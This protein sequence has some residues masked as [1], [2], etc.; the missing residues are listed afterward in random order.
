MPSKTPG[1]M[2]SSRLF[3]R[4][5]SRWRAG[6]LAMSVL[7]V[8]CTRDGGGEQIDQVVGVIEILEANHRPL[9]R[10]G[11]VAAGYPVGERMEL[12]DQF[13]V[14][15]RVRGGTVRLVHTGVVHGAV[16]GGHRNIG[17]EL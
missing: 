13:V 14:G 17:A 8:Q 11:P 2:M 16:A 7:S 1:A 5:F 4:S 9:D 12:R 6:V 3:N 10:L 15:D